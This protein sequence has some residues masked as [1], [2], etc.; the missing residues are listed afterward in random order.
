MPMLDICAE[1][2]VRIPTTCSVIHCLETGK[3]VLSTFF[4]ADGKNV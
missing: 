1:W 3:K 4:R 2:T